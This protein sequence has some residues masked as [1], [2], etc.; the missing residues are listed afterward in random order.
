MICQEAHEANSLSANYRWTG[1]MPRP[2]SFDYPA[3][4]NEASGHKQNVRDGVAY[5]VPLGGEV[6]T[7]PRPAGRGAFLG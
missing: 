2:Q 4:R 1:H 6:L 5:P 7:F 3:A